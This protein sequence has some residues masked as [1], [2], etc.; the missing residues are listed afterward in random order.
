MLVHEGYTSN[1]RGRP[2]FPQEFVWP[3]LEDRLAFVGLFHM[4]DGRPLHLGAPVAS[5]DPA[6]ILLA[7]CHHSSHLDIKKGLCY[8]SSH[9]DI[10]NCLCHHFSHLDVENSLCHHAQVTE[11]ARTVCVATSVTLT[12]RTVCV[13]MH[14]SP[15]QQEQFVSPLQSPEHQEQFVSLHVCHLD[16]RNT[17]ITH[18]S[19]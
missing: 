10:K 17:V 18:S 3:R 9:R 1:L 4:N 14:R 15:R 7:V 2:D 8:R 13:I 19:P 5:Q 16:T 11:T 6:S 12:S